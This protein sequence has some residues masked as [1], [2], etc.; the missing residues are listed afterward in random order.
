MARE[1]AW[2]APAAATAL[3]SSSPAPKA[4][5]NWAGNT[6]R[7]GRGRGEG[8]GVSLRGRHRG[9][10]LL[11]RGRRPAERHR[12]RLAERR[13]VRARRAR[14]QRARGLPPPVRLPP[15]GVTPRAYL[16]RPA[17]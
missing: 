12:Q 9:R 14:R 1:P 4:V 13:R 3:T 10:A 5:L 6:A 2:T 16:A 15:R 8:A 11:E 7:D 17:R